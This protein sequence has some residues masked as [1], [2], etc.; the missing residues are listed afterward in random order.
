MSTEIT[1]EI[2]PVE[3]TPAYIPIENTEGL[4]YKYRIQSPQITDHL[5]KNIPWLLF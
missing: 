4:Y 3:E 1:A 5:L 2:T